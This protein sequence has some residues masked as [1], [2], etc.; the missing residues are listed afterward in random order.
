MVNYSL[1]TGGRENLSDREMDEI[2]S[3][4]ISN[5]ENTPM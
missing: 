3:E 1:P 2:L 5:S 4:S